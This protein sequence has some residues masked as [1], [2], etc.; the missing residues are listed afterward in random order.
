MGTSVYSLPNR[1]EDGTKVWY[2]LSL[3]MG[4]GMNFLY[5]DGYG[6]VKPVPIPLSSL[7][8]NGLVQ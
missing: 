7:M 4:M 6:I 2:S 8:T 1:D 5:V 3:A